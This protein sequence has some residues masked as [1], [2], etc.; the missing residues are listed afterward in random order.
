MNERLRKSRYCI[1]LHRD[2]IYLAYTAATNSFYEISSYVFH[3]LERLDMDVDELPHAKNKEEVEA[4]RK[5]QL[6]TTI[7]EDDTIADALRLRYLTNCFSKETIGLTFAPTLQCNLRCP[8]CY[9]KNKPLLIMNKETCNHVLSFIDNH[10]QSKYLSL[11][12]YGGEPLVGHD[13][14]AYFLSKVDELKHLKL[15]HHGMVTNA[16]LLHGERL[17]LFKEHP[18]NSI[19]ITL[20]GKRETHDLRR[21][22]H[23]GSGTYDQIMENLQQFVQ[24]YPDSLIGIRVNIDRNNAH[25]FIEIYE[26]FKLLFPNKK[27]IFVYPG[28]LRHCGKREADSPFLLNDEIVD[29]K[30]KFSEHGCH[31]EFPRHV[32]SGC[33]ANNITGYVVGPEGEIYKCWEDVGD[34]Q[35]VVGNVKEKQFTNLSLL[36]DYMLRSSNLQDPECNDCPL[37]PICTSNCPKFRLANKLNHA[38]NELCSLYMN[39]DYEALADCLYKYYFMKKQ[40]KSN[41]DI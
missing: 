15:I 41:C 37:L 16:T 31:L 39:K 10:R 19:Q 23:D 40:C 2:N 21:I 28:I 36:A 4:L 24:V 5:K 3:L 1:L 20:D 32:I 6:V 7:L 27:N 13:I 25:E 33:T 8:Y 11:T 30:R 14:I 22:R 18:L 17:D 29:L 12:W 9:E 35:C 26:Q 38:E 34:K